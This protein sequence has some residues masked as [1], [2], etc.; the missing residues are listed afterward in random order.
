VR[1][2]R[3]LMRRRVIHYVN[4]HKEDNSLIYNDSFTDNDSEANINMFTYFKTDWILLIEN[5][6]LRKLLHR[7]SWCVRNL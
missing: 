3:S 2:S 7:K 5:T 4:Y 6:I 1:S